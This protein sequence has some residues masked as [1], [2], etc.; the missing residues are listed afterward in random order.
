MI[1]NPMK[2]T[3]QG[4]VM[5]AA[6]HECMIKA[7]SQGVT[8]NEQI[9]ILAMAAALLIAHLDDARYRKQAQDYLQNK[10]R[11]YVREFRKEGVSGAVIKP[12]DKMQ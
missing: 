10:T 12:L 9:N 7:A 1:D 8:A 3:D 2:F 4:A 11:V 6:L 5:T